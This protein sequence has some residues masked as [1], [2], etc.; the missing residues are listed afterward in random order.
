MTTEVME[1]AQESAGLVHLLSA[2]PGSQ[3][4]ALGMRHEIQ[5]CLT[6][7]DCDREYVGH[8]LSLLL[9]TG[10]WRRL[11]NARGAPFRSFLHFCH[12]STPPGLGLTRAQVESL[13]V[14]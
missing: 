4:W 1:S 2:P 8:C 13:L 9:R 12:A 5:S 7:T 3:S 10:G 14:D 6:E 11:Q